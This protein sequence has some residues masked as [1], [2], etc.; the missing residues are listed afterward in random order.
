MLYRKP[1]NGKRWW[2]AEQRNQAAEAACVATFSESNKDAVARANCLNEADKK[3]SSFVK[4]PDLLNLLIAKRSQLAERQAAGKITRAEMML[5][6]NELLAKVTSEEQRRDNDANAVAAQQQANNN[7][8]ALLMLQTIQANR[9]AP[10][11]PP[12]PT[13]NTSCQTLG[14]NTYCQTR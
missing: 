12:A 1:N 3:E 14:T 10:P 8:A 9:P 5:E 11:P 4:Y 13:I 2:L 7:A 6:Y